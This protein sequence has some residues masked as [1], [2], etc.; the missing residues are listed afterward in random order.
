MSVLYHPGN[1]I[2]VLIALT[3]MTMGSVSQIDEEKKY[4]VKNVHRLARLGVIYEDSPNGGFMV[5]HNSE[6]SLVVEV[7]PKRHLDKSLMELKKSILRKLNEAIS[8]RGDG[9]F[10][11]KGR[12][13]V[14]KVDG[15]KN[16]IYSIH[17]GSTK[18]YHDLKEMNTRRTTAR[19]VVDEIENVGETMQG[20][21]VPPQV[22][23]AANE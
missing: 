7:K 17:S 5:Y 6:S 9:F 16:Q 11:N 12:L 20:N 3:R 2:V 22:Q 4:L 21:Q 19:I 14:F 13:C 23:A 8:L 1:A 18:M 15:L 10:M